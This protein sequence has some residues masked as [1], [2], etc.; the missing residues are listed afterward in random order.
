MRSILLDVKGGSGSVAWLSD[1]VSP[2]LVLSWELVRVVRREQPRSSSRLGEEDAQGRGQRRPLQDRRAHRQLRRVLAHPEQGPPQVQEEGEAHSQVK[3]QL[4]L[5][6][7][8][9]LL[10]QLQDVFQ[11]VLRVF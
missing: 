2:F 10:F 8:Q 11:G 7:S 4:C 5:M 1:A 6:S 9:I 3:T